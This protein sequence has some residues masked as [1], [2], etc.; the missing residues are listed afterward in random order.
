M[1]I[2]IFL[3]FYFFA[4]ITLVA[5][6]HRAVSP[7]HS[8]TATSSLLADPG[9]APNLSDSTSV[10]ASLYRASRP[11][12]FHLLHTK[13]ELKP[14]FETSQLDGKAWIR[15]QVGFYPVRHLDLD[16]Q[17]F[18]IQR[19]ALRTLD[20]DSN[21][22]IEL[23]YRYN[24]KVISAQ[25][26]KTLAGG[27]LLEIH[28]DYLA[29]PDSLNAGV[30]S[31]AIQGEKGL[32]F[33]RP[34]SVYPDKPLQVWTQGETDHNS[35]WFPTID[36]PNQKMTQEIS[37]CVDSNMVTLSNGILVSSIRNQDGTRTDIWSHHLPHA[38]YLAMIAAGKFS[39]TKDR[40]RNIPVH[41]YVEPQY[42]SLAARIF[43]RTPDML[44]YYSRI[45]G[46]DYP[47]SSY[48]QIAVRDFV[49]GAME[50]TG[51]VVFGQWAQRSVR[52][53]VDGSAE[54]TVAHEMFHHWFGDLVTCES[55]SNLSLNESFATYGTPL[56][57]EHAYGREEADAALEGNLKDYLAESRRK[58][59]DLIR[60]YYED[61]EDMFDR[62]SYAKGARILHMLRNE[63]GDKAFF[64]S[65]R[66]Y[67]TKHAFKAAEVHDFRLA[68]E[69]VTG[70]DLQV[71]FNQWFLS[72]GHP[73]LSMKY[74]YD[75][76]NKQ[77]VFNLSQKH[78]AIPGKL[79]SLPIQLE[80]YFFDSSASKQ[81][82]LE[83]LEQ[84]FRFN[85]P[86]PVWTGHDLG[87]IVLCE[88][89]D[90]RTFEEFVLQFKGGLFY[91]D[92][93]RALEQLVR[94]PQFFGAWG[95]PARVTDAME[96]QNMITRAL[97]DPSP[98]IRSL[99]AESI[100]VSILKQ[101]FLLYKLLSKTAESDTRSSVR[102]RA[103]LKLIE[104]ADSGKA[105]EIGWLEKILTTD[106]SLLVAATGLNGL[107]KDN[108]TIAL[109][110]ARSLEVEP[111]MVGSLMDF[112]AAHGEVQDLQFVEKSLLQF[113]DARSQRQFAGW[114]KAY[115]KAVL[116]LDKRTRGIA[117]YE[118]L[119]QHPSGRIRTI[120]AE[121]RPGIDEK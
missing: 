35:C 114:L 95:D 115:N 38:P 70:R 86:K 62:H 100:P 56:W 47:W 51:A 6:T 26:P 65:L 109:A 110:M 94:N 58:Q 7:V 8:R 49:S 31:A 83:K 67:L 18:T 14:L 71:F 76:N 102:Q 119:A 10:W 89:D 112:Y 87:R 3:F 72:K 13:L 36:A 68:C 104:T 12:D 93:K 50:N 5:C 33:I 107:V 88:Y 32:Y 113:R 78:S 24:R 118:K 22:W 17:G 106:S 66:V 73:V 41:Y 63:I 80:F 61:N 84:E 11:L 55:W 97:R 44:D 111:S 69:E 59:V 82:V 4:T 77:C 120:A 57:Y 20:I 28:M 43:H 23:P 39:V 54:G 60:Y 108:P 30:G 45:L 9:L 42:A 92:R 101:D 27:T 74:H 90:H 81:I 21:R 40:W 48:H 117:L 99:A 96:Y 105:L 98:V 53:L 103:L 1:P 25:L 19:L 121:Y 52:E 75:D 15:L 2:K 64:E 91:Y 79:F 16:A 85:L 116:R 29:S 46:V 34:D 37:I